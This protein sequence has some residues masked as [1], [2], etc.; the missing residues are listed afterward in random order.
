MTKFESLNRLDGDRGSHRFRSLSRVRRGQ[1]SKGFALVVTIAMMVLLMMLAMGSISLSAVESR[2]TSTSS[3]R[4]KARANARLA[5]SM[6]LGQMQETIGPDRRVTA[7]ASILDDGVDPNKRNWTTVWDTSEWDV[8]DP[9]DSRDQDAYLGALVSRIDTSAAETRSTATADFR[10]A[11]DSSDTTWKLLVGEGSVIEEDDYVYAQA[12]EV[13]SGS[14]TGS[15]AYWVGDEGVKARF[16]VN[17][18]EDSAA[19]DWA[20]AGRMGQAPGTGVHMMTGLEDYTDYLPDGSGEDDLVKFVDQQTL[21]LS[22]IESDA[23]RNRFHE[24]TTTH[25]GLLVDN[26]WGGIRRDLSTAFELEPE[27]FGEIDDFNDSG[28]SNDTSSYS[29]YSPSDATSNPLYYSQDTDES[30]GYVYEVPVDSSNRYRGPTWDILRNHYRL[31]K[32]ERNDLGFLGDPSASSD[33]LIAHGVMP[34]SYNRDPSAAESAANSSLGSQIAGPNVTGGGA[35]QV[36]VVAAHGE[37][38]GHNYQAGGRTE[39]TV[40]KITPQLIRAVFVYGMAKEEDEYFLTID[41]FFVIHN[42][43]NQPIE[44]YS[45]A[46]DLNGMN[47]MVSFTAQ[48]L[49]A[50][51]S[52]IKNVTF[53]VQESGTVGDLKSLQSFR[54]EE[55]SSGKYRMEPGEIRIVS[56]EPG[57][58]DLGEDAKVIRLAQMQYNVGAGVYLGNSGQEMNLKANTSI[59]VSGQLTQASLNVST[60]FTRLLHP[61][62]A[63]GGRFDL[64][65]LTTLNQS[66]ANRNHDVEAMTLIQQMRIFAYDQVLSGDNARVANVNQ[67]PTPDNGAFY[68]YAMDISLKDFS[69]DVAVMNDFN[70][71]ALG[72]EPREYDGGD[73]VAPNWEMSLQQSDLYDLQL[74]DA[75]GRGYWGEGKTAASGGESQVVLFDLP[76]TPPVSLGAFQHADTSKLNF[77]AMRSIANSRPQVGQNDLTQIYNRLSAVRTPTTPRYQ[78]DTSWA[79]NE[80][81]W[82]RYFFSGL[83]WGD[84]GES[85]L[86]YS[87]QNEALQ[88]LLEEDP[89]EVLVNSRMTLVKQP[90]EDDLEE[91]EDYSKIG[92]YLGI[93]GAFNVNST[94]VEAW[95]AVLASLSGRK[96]SYLNS[97]GSLTEETMGN[98]VAPLSRFT[99]PAGSD[100]DD[101]MGFRA[102][103]DDELEELAEAIVDQVKLRGPFMGLSDFVN[104]RLASDETGLAG[105]LQAAIDEADLNRSVSIGSVSDRGLLQSSPDAN[106]G[107]ARHL[108]QGDILTALGPIIATR[109]DTFVVR[110][111]GESTDTNGEVRARAWCEAVV[112]RTPEWVVETDEEATVSN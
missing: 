69:G 107:M 94:S 13:D 45:M 74:S 35:Y 89:Q 36:P 100:D 72:V 91:M 63:K 34:F 73:A 8:N 58:S 29:S 87:S 108:N 49:D 10:E 46:F 38:G 50:E 76:R 37:G 109:S 77:H 26:R 55:P 12:I 24:V 21:H 44:F 112:Q 11:V 15:Y 95:K 103:G 43:Y 9:V 3:H 99:T 5:L 1:G 42:P 14:N 67:I 52:G 41:P 101:Y 47:K 65:S 20:S 22:Q 83:C 104:R 17:S 105:A 98:D 59:V 64:E 78:I 7:P 2:K 53:Q 56:A 39:P 25:T 90:T 30:L 61:Q 66:S 33:A 40:Q 23:L 51:T 62:F 102:L 19:Q 88:A 18:P 16:D 82:D 84:S 70:H 96:V 71:R 111:Y 75:Q 93:A 80:A 6:A 57:R 106:E 27:E 60:I 54:L 97:N 79:A 110:A 32:K 4:M 81:L 28:E 48:Y 68:L 31:Y 86:P 92:E 85:S